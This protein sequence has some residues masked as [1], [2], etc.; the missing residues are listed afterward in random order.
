M[1]WGKRNV[2]RILV[3]IPEGKR[4]IAISRRGWKNDTSTCLQNWDGLI[5]T[6]FM[7]PRQGSEA[8]SFKN[9]NELPEI[10]E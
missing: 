8:K 3:G 10:L 1:H 5:W 6:G 2:Y 4:P 9:G 7:Y